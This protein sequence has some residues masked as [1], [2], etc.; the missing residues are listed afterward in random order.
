MRTNR[1]FF[2]FLLGISSVFAPGQQS[3]APDPQPGSIAGTVM[4]IDGGAIPGAT[5]TADGPTPD[6]HH[7]ATSDGTGTFLV[8]DLHPAVSYHVIVRA[9]GFAD[10][11]SPDAVVLHPG[12]EWL[13]TNINLKI[14]V[15]E[16]SVAAVFPEQLA[17]EQVRAAE[18]QR[19]L[20]FIPNFYVVY[21]WN[22]V[23]LT[24]KLKYKLALRTAVDP[25]SIAADVVLAGV[26]QAGD[27]PDYQQ[28][29]KG[30]FQRFGAAYTNGFS[31]IMIGGAVLPSLLHQDP[32]YFYKGTGTTKSRFLHAL[33]SPVW[34]KGDN[35]VWQINY[36]SIGGDLASGAISNIY[37][38]DSNRGPGLVFG[39]AAINS[40]ARVIDALAQEFILRKF[41]SHSADK[42]QP[43]LQRQ[44]P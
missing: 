37:Y 30:Y 3:S 15:V 39:T 12:Q 20:G 19:V 14:S 24:P 25:V 7:T 27:T 41:T 22:A 9:K 28:G 1:A 33:S 32:R 38:P 2:V 5:V 34:C 16:T 4:D 6:D 10:W 8:K 29:I 23:P 31:E 36:S 13:L 11:S 17:L 42:D 18:K 40:G 21:D 43:G 26:N 35:G 44:V